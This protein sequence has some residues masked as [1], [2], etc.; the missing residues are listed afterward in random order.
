MKTIIITE[1]QIKR[2]ID[3]VINEGSHKSN[4][5]KEGGHKSNELKD[6]VSWAVNKLGCR[7]M[8]TKD[9]GKICAPKDKNSNCYSYHIGPKAVEPVKSY[10]R[11]SFGV[12]K[13]ELEKAFKE[14][15]GL[16]KVDDKKE[17][18]KDSK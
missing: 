11:K 7:D 8:D 6:V 14:N 10:L 9:G 4:E 5:L 17:K 2:V 1:S 18:E 3:S 13:Q 15:V 16:S 12:S